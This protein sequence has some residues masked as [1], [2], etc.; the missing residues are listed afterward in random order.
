MT[1]DSLFQ[2]A[3]TVVLSG[4]LALAFAPLARARLVLIARIIAVLLSG[5]YVSLLVAGLAGDGPPAGASFDTLDG[6]RLLLSSP[7]ALLAGWV[8]YLVF[9]LWVG[10]WE[11]ED[12]ALPHWLLLPCLV[13]TFVAGPTGLLLYHLLKAAR[14]LRT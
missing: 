6:V 8:H 7:A 11:A 13:L 3:S 1:P 5:M 2:I 4:W 12:D 9:D 14:R 10:S